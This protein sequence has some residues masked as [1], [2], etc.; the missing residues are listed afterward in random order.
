MREHLSWI[1]EQQAAFYKQLTGLVRE[2]KANGTALWALVGFS[3]LYGVFHAAGPG[4]G[5][6]VISSYVLANE[7]SARRGMAIS[8]M[9]AFLQGLVAVGLIGAATFVF[10]LTSFAVTETALWFERAA[11]ALLAGLG[12]YLL[13]QKA[14]YPFLQYVR[15]TQPEPAVAGVSLGGHH[16]DHHDHGHG[17]DHQHHGHDHSHD[18]HHGHGHHHHDHSCGCGGHAADPNSLTSPL[19][20]K[21]AWA[22]ILSVGLRPCTGALVVLVFA[23]AQGM[24]WA[25]VLATMAMSLGTGITVTT[26]ASLALGAKHFASRYLLMEQGG[27]W[28]F[29]AVEVLGASLVFLFG[30]TL[31]SASLFGA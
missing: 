2:A 29:R 22:A 23:A 15:D 14:L 25:G 9:S 30:I 31:L 26:L 21:S 12:L 1:Y 5:K 6:V 17:H 13:W 3:F 20:L 27:A 10:N 8:F 7:Q 28:V 19:T 16:H 18:H 4:H 24:F 11:Y